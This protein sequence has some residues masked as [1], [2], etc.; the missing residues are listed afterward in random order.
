M[1]ASLLS[2]HVQCNMV[3]PAL[4]AGKCWDSCHVLVL[5]SCDKMDSGQMPGGLTCAAKPS[6]PP[7]GRRRA[8]YSARAAA[9]LTEPVHC[10]A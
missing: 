9:A 1:R 3:T 6:G 5:H 10:S 4:R 2:L 8:W 7:V